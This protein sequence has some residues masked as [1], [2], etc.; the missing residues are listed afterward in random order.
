MSHTWTLADVAKH[1]DS[2]DNY[3]ASNAL[4]DSYLRRFTDSA[5][6]FAMPSNANVLDIDCRTGN[7]TVFFSRKYPDAS[8]TCLASAQSFVQ[9][10]RKRLQEEVIAANA[11]QFTALPLSL[12]DAHFDVILSYETL[13]HMPEPEIFTQELAR[14]LKPN[15]TLVLTTPNVLWE[16]VHWLSA[17]LHLDHGEGPHRMIPRKEIL[18]AFANAKLRVLREKTC[19]LIPA[20]PHWLL[21]LG[22]ALETLFPE[23]LLRILALRR[24]FICT[25]HG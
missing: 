25:K 5:L 4:I 18:R 14:V 16:P 22:K 11:A 23:W 10:A 6:L 7:G 19:V 3:D 1:W 21:S 17:K 9:A 2:C 8:F 13:E 15:G 24:T 20:G 12:P